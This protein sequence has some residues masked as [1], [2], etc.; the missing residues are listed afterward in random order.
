MKLKFA[1]LFLCFLSSALVAGD[2]R[3]LPPDPNQAI[4]GSRIQRFM[5]LLEMSQQLHDFPVKVLVYG[6]SIM[7]QRAADQS[8]QQ[9]K[10]R[11][12]YA[13]LIVENRAI[14]G[15]TAPSLVHAAETDLYP[16]YPDLLIFHV[17]G[18]EVRGEFERIISNVRRYTTADIMLLTHHID[19]RDEQGVWDA[20]SAWRRGIAQKYNCELVD[21]RL[22]WKSYLEAHGLQASDLLKDHIHLNEHGI[23]LHRAI[24]SRHFQV[25]PSGHHKWMDTVRSYEIARPAYERM[26][27]LE[28][29]QQAWNPWA[30][31]GEDP[32]RIQGNRL[33]LEFFG[34]RVDVRT[35]RAAEA[36]GTATILIDG[37]KPS[38]FAET[39][40]ATRVNQGPRSWFPGYFTIQPGRAPVAEKWVMRIG[41][42]AEKGMA[43]P[44][45][46]TGSSTGLDGEGTL[47]D[48]FVSASNRFSLLSQH[49]TLFKGPA[50]KPMPADYE[51]RWEIYQM[52]TDVWVP[53]MPKDENSIAQF[54]LVQGLSNARHTLEI[55]PNGDGVLPLK[56]IVIHSP[57]LK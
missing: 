50:S 47:R 5:G 36:L 48:D 33:K 14:G 53:A 56:E 18:G 44:F 41:Q 19:S 1:G 16:F 15:C 52:G 6:Q 51:L 29:S 4:F 32:S 22:V 2:L 37:K 54:T 30:K 55:I 21:V 26:R 9:L 49:L 38:E 27:D 40:A 42:L 24:I 35:V 13:K 11:Y 7:A 23:A 8:V 10:E 43:A 3:T 39:F 45:S 28:F 12:P 17:Y 31:K 20:A 25:N 34:N 46:V 57:S